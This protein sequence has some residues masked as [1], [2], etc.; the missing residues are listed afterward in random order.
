[1]TC[2]AAGFL[3]FGPTAQLVSNIEAASASNDM[4]CDLYDS[5][6]FIFNML[7]FALH[8]GAIDDRQRVFG[9]D[10]C[11]ATEARGGASM[12]QDRLRRNI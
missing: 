7:E 6:I 10:G 8:R 4:T 5:V 1:M 11:Q 2:G 9:A 3:K 12:I